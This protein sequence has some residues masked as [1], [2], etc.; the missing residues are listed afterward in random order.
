VYLFCVC[1]VLCV[2][3][4]LAT[5]RSLVQGVLQTVYKIKKLKIRPKS[6]RAAEPWMD[7]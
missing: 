7:R 5:G 4:G 2:G 1:V 6:T 3:N